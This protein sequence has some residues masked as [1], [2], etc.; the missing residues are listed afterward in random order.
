MKIKASEATREQR[1]SHPS[2]SESVL[3]T[4]TTVHVLTIMRCPVRAGLGFVSVCVPGT[5]SGERR[6]PTRCTPE[7]G[8]VSD[9]PSPV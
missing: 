9:T 4:M 7:D 1:V 2:A 3:L 6:A 5:V 8:C